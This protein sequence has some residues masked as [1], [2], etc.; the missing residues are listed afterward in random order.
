MRDLLLA[1]AGLEHN[2]LLAQEFGKEIMELEEAESKRILLGKITTQ[3]DELYLQYT[4]IR[5]TLR[6]LMPTNVMAD[7]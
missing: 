7:H 3:V 6:E 5:H 1:L 2:L 4:T